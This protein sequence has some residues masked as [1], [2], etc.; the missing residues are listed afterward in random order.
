M[1]TQDC[2]APKRCPCRG[3]TSLLTHPPP[4]QQKTSGL[5]SQ[6]RTT[7]YKQ[8]TQTDRRKQRHRVRE[9]DYPLR[10][11]MMLVVVS[12]LGHV[13]AVKTNSW[14]RKRGSR[15]S[16]ARSASMNMLRLKI[17]RIRRSIFQGSDSA[18][19]KACGAGVM[20]DCCAQGDTR[21]A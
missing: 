17:N 18:L 2:P 15:T 20:E 13:P 8:L 11:R 6:P 10:K 16:E 5:Q 21:T 7:N 3:L 14:A 9:V 12:G 4:A 1:H 19:L